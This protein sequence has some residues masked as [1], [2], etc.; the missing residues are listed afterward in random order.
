MKAPGAAAGCCCTTTTSGWANSRGAEQT[1]QQQQRLS[2]A[3][4]NAPLQSSAKRT[5]PLTKQARR[6]LGWT[7]L[8]GWGSAA[9][10]RS[11]FQ[12]QP[13]HEVVLPAAVLRHALMQR[14]VTFVHG[15]LRPWLMTGMELLGP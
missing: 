10:L 13:K 8:T 2:W 7:D 5:E 3:L 1:Q 14:H 6:Q 11:S 9:L 15:A 4:C 12:L